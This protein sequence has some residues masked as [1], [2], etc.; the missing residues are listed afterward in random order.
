MQRNHIGLNLAGFTRVVSFLICLVALSSIS[1]AQVGSASLS[2]IVQDKTEAV[3]PGADLTLQ[4]NAS[5]VQRA[6]HSNGAGIFSF[7]G[8]PSGDY[9]LTIQRSGFKQL[10]RSSI[11]LNPG[12]ALTLANLKL[13][14][15][16]VSQTVTVQAEIAG[17]PLDNG[18]LSSTISANDIDRLSIVGRDATELQKILPGFAIRATVGGGGGAAQN[19]APDFSQVQVGQPTP[20]ASN[21]A[22]VAG[23]T[24]KLDGANLTDAGNFGANLMNI[25]DA[26]VSEVQ[27]QTSNFAAD[28]SNGP[29]V[30]TGVTKSGTAKYHGSLYSYARTYQLNSNDWLS[31]YNGFARP[32]DFF[33]Y[34]GATISGPIPHTKKLTF[35]AGAEY[36]G[37]RNV[38]AYGSAGSAIIHALVPTATMRTGNFS[39]AAINNLLGP[40]AI[41]SG[42][43]QAGSGTYATFNTAPANG[44]DD[45]PTP[46]GN[47][48]AWLNP[49]AMA[50]VN[51]TLPL[52]TRTATGADGFNYDNVDL[53]NNNVSQ[54]A[55]RLDYAI[56]PR[57]QFFVRYSFEKGRQ[58]QPLV[59][60][61]SP[62]G[63]SLMGAVNTPGY[64]VNNDT[65][66]HS[67]SANYVTIFTP[68]LTNEVYA[69]LTYFL[70]SFDARQIG[71]LQKGAINYPY[72]GAFDNHDTQYPQLGTYTTYG[73]LPLGL[74]PDY[75]NNPLELQ[76][77]Q[78]NIGD[79]LTK[80]WGR[81]TVKI[82]IFTQRTKNNQTATNPQTNGVIQDYYYGGA[83]SY[84]ADYNGTYPDGSPAYG[85]PHFN[86][87]NALA[88]FF[89]GQIQDWHQQ[90]FNPYTNLYF[91]DLDFYAQDTIHVAS[92]LVVTVGARVS[93]MSA[94]EDKHNIG[95]AVFEASLVTSA[96]N[97]QTNPVPGLTWHGENASI[98]NAGV[99]APPIFFEPRV[100]FALDLFK[101]GKT[102]V[103][104][105]LGIYRFHDAVTDVANQFQE[106][107]HVRYT[108]LQGFGDNTLEGVNTLHLNPNTYGNAGGTETF[109]SPPTIYG[110]DPTSNQEPV[111]NNYSLSVAQQMPGKF[112]LQVSYVGNNSNS[113]MDNG[114]TQTV[115]LDNINAIPVGYLFTPAAAA[116]INKYAPGSCNATG[117]TPQQAGRLDT[118]YN[119]PGDDSIQNARPYPEYNQII[120]PEHNTFAN[121]NGLQVEA[122]KQIGRLNFNVNYTFSKALGILGSAADFNYTAGVDPFHLYNNY[123]PMNYD[124]SQVLNLSYSYQTGRFTTE[125]LL[126]GFINNWLI[127]G[128]TNVQSGPNMQTGVSPSP[129]YYVQGSIGTGASFY[130]VSNTT[131]LGTPDVSLQP[132]LTCNPAR[133]LQGQQ[134]LNASCFS[135][136]ATGTN[137][138][139]IEPYAH[140]PAFINSDLSLEKGFGLGG[141]RRLRFRYAAF[142]F[143]NHPLYS[144]GTNYASETTLALSTASNSPSAAAP[145]PGNDFGITEQKLGRRLSEISLKF[146]F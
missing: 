42:A 92:N 23:T 79:N 89:E 133:G 121:Y 63:S 95:A 87:G 102:V 115:V 50:L 30:I 117:C 72:N 138:Q 103:R 19:S 91:W 129:G 126:G 55:G 62:A 131:I 36:D 49:G 64:G 144:F 10:V 39:Q 114:T 112:I 11:H 56:S 69:T 90:N 5:G 96:A 88:N 25:D 119:Y 122:I 7:S 33:F 45:T 28:Q 83:G 65:W 15:G 26:F 109:I 93:K 34:P 22:P 53:V 16:E 106:A 20:Y 97:S 101:N 70:Q 66:V 98:P 48:A 1:R 136:P 135:L 60:Y 4:N 73:G 77:L 127:S 37:Q 81:N 110:L 82:G 78:P 113:L 123:G 132:A 14:V 40:F 2:G 107:E 104:G 75:S 9:T 18:Q 46:T 85:N 99:S 146:D 68:T 71:A 86:S 8:V 139:Y 54:F 118:I 44:D 67:A 59:P 145:T 17:L 47:I 128:I 80:V 137:G 134:H 43:P 3:V 58:G 108:D 35:F 143:L 140:G 38:Y 130:G 61:Y 100:G 32:N 57:N 27:V 105:G 142:N 51:G 29:V 21:G 125:R 6:S 24:L 52:P 74:W 94:W 141:E 124:R 41:G 84:F 31:K 12:D 13:D 120:V 116:A 111:T 76:K